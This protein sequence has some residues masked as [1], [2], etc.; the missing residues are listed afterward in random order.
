MGK[1]EKWG[2]V[3]FGEGHFEKLHEN[4]IKYTTI[5]IDLFIMQNK[6][7]EKRNVWNLHGK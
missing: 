3:S 1:N 6:R 7:E 5:N 4:S 2:C